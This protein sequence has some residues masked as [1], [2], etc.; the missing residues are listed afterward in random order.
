MSVPYLVAPYCMPVPAILRCTIPFLST[1]LRS[2]ILH[3]STAHPIAASH[4]TRAPYTPQPQ[5]T[6]CQHRTRKSTPCA[7]TAHAKAHRVPAP[8]KQ[9]HTVCQ[10]RTRKITPCT[11]TDIRRCI[12]FQIVRHARLRGYAPKSHIRNRL[13]GTHCTEK[14]VACI[15][16]R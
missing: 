14:A 2:T 1:V 16:L 12:C 11:S 7:S 9:K 13:P 3:V 10:H 15:G 5:H 8:H 6:V 4:C